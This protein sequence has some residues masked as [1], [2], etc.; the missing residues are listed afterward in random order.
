MISNKSIRADARTLLTRRIFSRNWMMALLICL[1]QVAAITLLDGIFLI[2]TLLFSSFCVY[3]YASIFLPMIR[4]DKDNVEFT[5]FFKGFD[6]I[7]GLIALSLMTN[8]FVLL[9]SLLFIV[10]GIIKSYS[11]AMAP[12]IKYDHPEYGWKRCLDESRRMMKG[13]KWKLFCLKLSFLGWSIVGLL[14]CCV[15]IYWV[16]PYSRAAQVCFYEELKAMEG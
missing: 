16:A 6:R 10:P 9:W 8:L 1:V 11:Y 4:G 5:A 12:Y 14:C 15:G 3:G 13:H 7:G 2:G